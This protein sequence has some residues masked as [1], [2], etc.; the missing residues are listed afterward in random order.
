[1][2]HFIFVH[3]GNV[4]SNAWDELTQRQDFPDNERLGGKVWCKMAPIL[5]S[6]GHTA[7]TPTLKNE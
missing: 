5:K 1:M 7:H 3:G 4:N 2:T 6:L